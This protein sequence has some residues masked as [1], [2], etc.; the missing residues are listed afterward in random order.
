VKIDGKNGRYGT[1]R[2]IKRI[3]ESQVFTLV[4]LLI[5]AAILG[6]LAAVIL[7]A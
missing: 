1:R 4:E 2:L 5:A 7:P 6:V 3:H